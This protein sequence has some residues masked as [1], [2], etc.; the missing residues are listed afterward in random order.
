MI[1]NYFLFSSLL[2]LLT[3]CASE[4]AQPSKPE[5]PELKTYTGMIRYDRGFSNFT[6]CATGK[7]YLLA[8]STKTIG[9]LHFRACQPAQCPE[10]KVFAKVN[11]RLFPGMGKAE[12]DPGTLGV[13]EVLELSAA[14]P[15][16]TCLP[17]EYWCGDDQKTWSL[18]L[19]L[20]NNR[21]FF[22]DLSGNK[23]ATFQWSAPVKKGSNITYLL[24]NTLQPTNQLELVIQS[25]PCAGQEGATTAYVTYQGKRYVGCAKN[26]G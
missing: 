5:P 6:D 2:L 10:E 14:T 16:N 25:N 15:E 23:G 19:S 1:N 4:V 17:F 26:P 13:V 18:L 3:G 11:A 12:N 8:D 9:A 7:L 22:K 24:Q 20:E 21:A